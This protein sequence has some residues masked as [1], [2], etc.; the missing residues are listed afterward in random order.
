MN[1]LNNGSFKRRLEEDALELARILYGLF[2][3]Q[4]NQ[5]LHIEEMYDKNSSYRKL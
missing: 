3:K 2:I 1:R 5:E 4:K